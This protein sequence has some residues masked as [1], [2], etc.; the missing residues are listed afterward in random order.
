[1]YSKANEF[2]LQ[3]TCIA[4]HFKGSPLDRRTM[5]P[6]RF[7]QGIKKTKNDN[8]TGKHDKKN[9]NNVLWEKV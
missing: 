3:P 7:V 2:H 8:Y 6:G 1:M 9:N 4:N 5:T